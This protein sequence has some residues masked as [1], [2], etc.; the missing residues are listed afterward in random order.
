MTLKQEIEA[1]QN[2][3]SKLQ[4]KS[5]CKSTPAE[6]EK[7]KGE[8]WDKN[9]LLSEKTVELKL[10]VIKSLYVLMSNNSSYNL[11]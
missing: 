8:I 10:K 1:L 5:V 11:R 9:K 3:R 4:L 7:I 2:E 6:L